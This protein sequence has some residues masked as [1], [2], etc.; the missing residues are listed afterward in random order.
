M[1][2]TRSQAVAIVPRP[3]YEEKL[4]VKNQ[5]ANDISKLLRQAEFNSRSY[6]KKL[7]RYFDYGSDRDKCRIIWKFLR[8]NIEYR[9][10]PATRQTA[11]EISRLLSDGFGDCKHYSTFVVSMLLALEIPC[12]FRLVSFRQYDK[13]PTHAYAVALIDGEI[14]PI[15]ACIGIWGRESKYKWAYNIPPLK[16][17]NQ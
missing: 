17:V 7:S 1:N 15:D 4:I 16:K 13:S 11:K 14:I 8:Q 5:T 2:L 3:R 9:K 12:F 6:A 10:E